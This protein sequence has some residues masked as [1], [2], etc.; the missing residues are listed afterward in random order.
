MVSVTATF[1]QRNFAAC[2]DD[3]LREPVRITSHGRQRTALV[4]TEYLDALERRAG[5]VVMAAHEVPEDLSQKILAH[6]SVPAAAYALNQLLEGAE[7]D[8]RLVDDD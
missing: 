6:N 1:F 8:P 4:S 3:A 5:R 2:N 7:P